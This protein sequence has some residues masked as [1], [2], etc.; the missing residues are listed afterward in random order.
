MKK[1]LFKT[2]S[3]NFKQLKRN[4]RFQICYFRSVWL[5]F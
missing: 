1:A 4:W 2:R 5:N 3:L